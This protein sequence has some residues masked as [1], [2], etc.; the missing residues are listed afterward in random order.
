MPSFLGALLGTPF[1]LF[2]LMNYATNK[3]AANNVPYAHAIAVVETS[4]YG[5]ADKRCLK[6]G[7]ALF[8]AHRLDSNH[9]YTAR[10]RWMVEKGGDIDNIWDN[11][12]PLEKV[13][14]MAEFE[15]DEEAAKSALSYYLDQIRLEVQ[16][17]RY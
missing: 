11:L 2:P 6:V 1:V 12:T 9:D 8:L 10:V 16:K 7:N 5:E 3:S 14:L 15:N 13:Y 17:W 4:S